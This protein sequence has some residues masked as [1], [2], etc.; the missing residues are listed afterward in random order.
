MNDPTPTGT[1][2]EALPDQVRVPIV[3]KPGG[4]YQKY[5]FKPEDATRFTE[6]IEPYLSD[7]REFH[8]ALYG[9]QHVTLQNKEAMLSR[10]R[11]MLEELGELA[12]R[13]HEEDLVGTADGLIDL[14]YVTF[15]TADLLEIPV[16]AC[17]REVH[18]SN[19]TKDFTTVDVGKKGAVK[20]ARYSPPDLAP[21]LKNS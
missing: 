19:M 7:I 9:D 21:L 11:L 1:S 4:Q 3:V 5:D 12:C 15:G 13:I 17:W 8:R 10:V 18:R 6:P 16:A 2:F 20:G 14:L